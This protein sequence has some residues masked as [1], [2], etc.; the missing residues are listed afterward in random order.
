METRKILK[1][2]GNSLLDGIFPRRCPVCDRIVGG[3]SALICVK[4]RRQLDYIF[5]PKC[6][7][8]GKKL[9]EGGGQYCHD[10]S[11]KP[12]SFDSGLALY[13]Y[14][15]VKQSIYRF[16]YEGRCDYAEFF[17]REIAEFL[18]E[19]IGV[20]GAEALVPVPLHKGRERKRGYNQA[21][22]LAEVMSGY[23]S[24]PV[25]AGL[26]KRSRNTV[27]Q[28]ELNHAARQKNLKKAFKIPANDVKLKTIII[29]DDIY[30]TGSTMDALSKELKRAGVQKVYFIALSIGEGM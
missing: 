18:G 2:L 19:E 14:H 26:V 20:W 11:V 15:S 1:K 27:P 17:G 30:T 13:E 25:E 4:C 23:L 8:C 16:K 28:K 29:V 3:S 5:E 6:K 12:H 22:L 9:H 10:C 21:E 24:I 7:K